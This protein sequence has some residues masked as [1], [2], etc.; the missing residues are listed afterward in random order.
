MLLRLEMEIRGNTEKDVMAE[1]KEIAKG[2]PPEKVGIAKTKVFRTQDGVR[3]RVE[4]IIPLSE[5]SWQ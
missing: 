1:A 5:K 3:Y 2:F 4:K